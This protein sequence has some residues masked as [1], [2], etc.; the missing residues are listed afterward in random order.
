[1]DKTEMKN[2]SIVDLKKEGESL[3]KELFNLKLGM[4]SGQV[5][6]VSQFGKLRKKVAQVLTYLNL[7]VKNERTK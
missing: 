7:K 3:K 4:I 6:D 5:K 2:L 1:M